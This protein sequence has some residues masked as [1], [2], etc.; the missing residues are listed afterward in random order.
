MGEKKI[1]ETPTCDKLR[2]VDATVLLRAMSS[3]KWTK[4][5]RNL[6]KLKDI[7]RAREEMD[8]VGDV[9]LTVKFEKIRPLITS[10]G[11]EEWFGSSGEFYVITTILDGSGRRIEY[12]TQ[13]F[14]GIKRGEFFPLGSGGMLIGFIKNPHWFVD[15]HMLIMESDSDIRNFGKFI[16][17]AKKEAKLDDLLKFVGAVATFD[18]TMVS[19]VVTGVNLFLA[20]LTHILKANGDDYIAVIHDFYLKHQKYGEGRHPKQGLKQ[21]QNVEAAY[22]IELTK[23]T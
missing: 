8:Q 23:L 1:I 13:F 2:E 5:P 17:E 21:W 11:I 18:P 12:T 14:Q 7:N 10:E 15:I 3:P 22:G 19:Q 16:E 6:S 9:G 4:D 20:T